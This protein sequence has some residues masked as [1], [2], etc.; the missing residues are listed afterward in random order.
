MESFPD[1]TN[2][3]DI[4]EMVSE[5]RKR[6]SDLA[7]FIVDTYARAMAEGGLSEMDPGEVMKFV[8][9]M[10]VLKRGF[11]CTV[12]AIH[13]SGKDLDRQARGS[14]ALLA[15]ADFGF[16]ITANWEGMALKLACAKMKS[17]KRF[18]PLHYEAIP[19]ED[20]LVIRGITASAYR[21]LTTVEDTLSSRSV[22]A[23]LAKV[24][25]VD[26]THAV[27]VH[28]LASALYV[29]QV[30]EPELEVQ[31]KL[32]RIARKL[33]SLGKGRLEQYVSAKGWS[34]PE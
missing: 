25:A 17:A 23:A 11:Q 5:I 20:S 9:Q 4:D 14:N 15:A 29:A 7:L 32:D 16:E 26:P 2:E 28:V 1:V 22:G 10:E 21:S 18:E 34:F 24:G 27:T 33:S 6:V 19:H 31:A 13:H 12:I 3:D 8:R 30:D